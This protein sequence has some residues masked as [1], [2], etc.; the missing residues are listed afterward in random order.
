MPPMLFFL[1]DASNKLFVFV[2]GRSA[3]RLTLQV[4][5]SASSMLFDAEG[6]G[7]TQKIENEIAPASQPERHLPRSYAIALV[8]QGSFVFCFVFCEASSSSSSS[9]NMMPTRIK[10]ANASHVL[11]NIP[12]TKGAQHKSK[13]GQKQKL[14]N[15]LG[16]GCFSFGSFHPLTIERMTVSC[17]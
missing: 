12:E 2:L 9:I 5:R 13:Q 16:L 7:E 8:M 1:C 4:M 6:D 15:W 11:R 10:H 14:V 17:A 3:M